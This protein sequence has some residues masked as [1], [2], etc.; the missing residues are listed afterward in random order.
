[1]S[2]HHSQDFR[3]VAPLCLLTLLAACDTSAPPG[4]APPMPTAP[5]AEATAE[6]GHRIRYYGVPARVGNGIARTY[7]LVNSDDRD[8]PVEVGVALSERAM[9]GLPAAR[10]TDEH[11]NMPPFAPLRV[12]YS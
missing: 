11:E 7:V 3:A 6:S 5:N 10:G 8:V 2:R 1:M 4:S 12:T 9:E